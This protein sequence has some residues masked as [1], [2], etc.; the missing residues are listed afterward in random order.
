MLCFHRVWKRG[1]SPFQRVL[2][3]MGD[4][5]WERIGTEDMIRHYR[6]TSRWME[7]GVVHEKLMLLPESPIPFEALG[8]HLIDS[9][10]VLED[11]EESVPLASQPELPLNI[12]KGKKVSTAKP[13]PGLFVNQI[14]HEQPKQS[15]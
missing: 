3:E 10:W 11:S 9:D 1:L 7:E 14:S 13:L 15:D 4:E 12:T 8:R 5:Q 2:W 6:I